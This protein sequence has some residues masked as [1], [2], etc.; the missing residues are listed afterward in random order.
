M[1]VRLNFMCI[2]CP[3]TVRAPVML[4]RT[5]YT[6]YPLISPLGFRGRSHDSPTF[7]SSMLVTVRF[8]GGLGTVAGR[9]RTWNRDEKKC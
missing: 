5:K 7:L 3:W 9:R 8:R 6:R 1:S 4:P 2:C